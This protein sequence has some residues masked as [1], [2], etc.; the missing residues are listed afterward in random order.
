[1]GGEEAE[2]AYNSLKARVSNEG[3][4]KVVVAGDRT[5]RGGRCFWDEECEK[6]KEGPGEGK[7]V[8]R[9]SKRCAHG[10]SEAFLSDLLNVTGSRIRFL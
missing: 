5:Q 8:K 7:T 3:K 4:G 10:A 9:E 1:M 6:E 2:T